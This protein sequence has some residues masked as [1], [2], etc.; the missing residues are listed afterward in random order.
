VV[1]GRDAATRICLPCIMPLRKGLIGNGPRGWGCEPR[2]GWADFVT[3]AKCVAVQILRALSRV[4][5]LVA[6]V[7]PP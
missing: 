5:A 6:L 4:V 3:G 7:P 2:R 1:G